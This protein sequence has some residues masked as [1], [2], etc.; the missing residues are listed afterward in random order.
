[1]TRRIWQCDN[2]CISVARVIAV[3]SARIPGRVVV[4][5][6]VV[7]GALAVVDALMG[8]FWRSCRE[9]MAN[10]GVMVAMLYLTTLSQFR[11]N[12]GAVWKLPLSDTSRLCA[13]SRGV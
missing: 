5:A 2:A 8:M 9:V 11:K 12:C 13:T 3:T 1:M 6:P 7:V 4:G 10:W